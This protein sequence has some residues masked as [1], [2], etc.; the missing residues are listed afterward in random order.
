MEV[1]YQ[2]LVAGGGSPLPKRRQ[3]LLDLLALGISL[4]ATIYGMSN[5]GAL[6]PLAPDERFAGRFC[7]GGQRF[8]FS[9]GQPTLGELRVRLDELPRPVQRAVHARLANGDG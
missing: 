8:E 7:G 2:D 1:T 9:D 3:E 4:D 6:R 5:G